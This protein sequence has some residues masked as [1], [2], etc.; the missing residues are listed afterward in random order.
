M[1]R[2]VL[3]VYLHHSVIFSMEFKSITSVARFIDKFFNPESFDI[4]FYLHDSIKDCSINVNEL[5]RIWHL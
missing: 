5:M 2:F 1:R 4:W 3:D